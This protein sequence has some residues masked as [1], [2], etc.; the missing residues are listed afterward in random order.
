MVEQ[1]HTDVLTAAEAVV[2][3]RL[4]KACPSLD[5]AR[6][7]LGRLSQDKRITPLRWGK[8]SLYSRQNLDRFVAAET[9]ALPVPSV[10]ESDDKPPS[11]AVGGDSGADGHKDGH[12]DW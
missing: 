8:E 12:K 3:L 1:H 2:Y 10:D 9:A 4:D 5:A 11:Q 6:K 7:L